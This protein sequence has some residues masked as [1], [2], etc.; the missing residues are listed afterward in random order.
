VTPRTRWLVMLGVERGLQA[1]VRERKLIRF[2]VAGRRAKGLLYPDTSFPSIEVYPS[3][4]SP[5]VC[6]STEYT[7]HESNGRE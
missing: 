5:Q 7:T 3:P 6:C 2:L 4:I 1:R